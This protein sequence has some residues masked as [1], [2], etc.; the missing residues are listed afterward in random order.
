M[1]RMSKQMKDEASLLKFK[2]MADKLNA[3]C[4]KEG[5]K[6]EEKVAVQV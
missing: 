4:I 5:Q 1:D 6:A 3:D 2:K